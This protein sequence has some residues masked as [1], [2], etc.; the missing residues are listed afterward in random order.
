MLAPERRRRS[1]L[2]VAA[3]LVVVAAIALGAIWL[4]SDARGTASESAKEPLP[5]ATTA[6]VVPVT[7]T[8]SW[9]A[10][11]PLT[12][13]PVV[14][15]SAVV[16]GN[17]GTVTGLDPRTGST[18]WTYRRDE[19]LC[20]V[21]SA[22][23]TALAVFRDGRGCTQVT[24]LEGST[25]SRKSQ[26]T[27]DADSDV[28]LTDD[29]TYVTSRGSTRMELWRSDLVRTLEY[30]RVDAP[31]NPHGQPRSGC[32][33][34]SSASNS[35]QLAVLETCPG[36]SGPRL[37]TLNPA[38]KDAQQPEEFGSSVIADLSGADGPIVGAAVLVASGDRVAL[39]LPA[40][41]KTPERPGKPARI[42]L[43]DGTAQP[44]TDFDLPAALTDQASF[45]GDERVEKAANVFSWW[46]GTGTVALGLSDLA[47]KWSLPGSLGPGVLMAGKLLVPMPG[48]IAVIDSGSGTAERT[49][50][51]NRAGYE[52]PVGISVLGD[53]IIEQRGDDIV[54]LSS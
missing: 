19:T 16:T 39:A 8:E 23:N 21:T 17:D 33:L 35:S 49:I 5:Q 15:G 45:G 43:F 27:S 2:I 20:A 32:T 46:T 1:D 51:V 47:P 37:T 22:W 6:T 40:Q 29:G 26:R 18:A 36:E 48:S 10:H 14:T 28:T 12:A 41:S 34:L 9:R 31:V 25:G 50:P 7:L 11:S 53:D 38:P 44:I 42:A 13:T 3:A 4:G 54:A 24:E 30:G 52:G